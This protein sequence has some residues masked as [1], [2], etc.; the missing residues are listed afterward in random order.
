MATSDPSSTLV[1]APSSTIVRTAS[2]TAYGSG[3]PDRTSPES[4]CPFVS[5]P[6]FV[7]QCTSAG[8]RSIS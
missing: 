6:T 7:P 1:T 8:P 5:P 3:N 4:P 2:P